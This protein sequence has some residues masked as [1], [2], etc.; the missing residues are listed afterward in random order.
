MKRLSILAAMLALVLTAA[1]GSTDGGITTAVKSKMAVDDAVK[2]YQVDVD[3]HEGVVT[4][5][6]T[7]GSNAARTRAVMLA[8][9]TDGVRDVIDNLRVSDAVATSGI[10]DDIDDAGDAAERGIREGADDA[11][12]ATRRAGESVRESDIDDKA[13]EAARDSGDAVADGARKV[14]NAAKKGA[15]AVADGAKKVG[16]EI[17]DVFTDDDPDTDKDGK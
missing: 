16:S 3:T 17:K 10:G 13:E 11:A 4:L 14:G 7:V 8:R 5:N 6:G 15:G 9:D 1:C 2:A 12:D